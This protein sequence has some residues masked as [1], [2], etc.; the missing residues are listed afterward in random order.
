[1]ALLKQLALKYLPKPLLRRIRASHY[2][3]QLRHYPLASEP[4]LLGCRELLQPGDVVIDVGANIGVYTRFCSEY[5]GA[6]GHVHSLEPIPE[7]F[8][9]LRTNVDA[10]KLGNVTLYPYAA[11]D[12]DET[13][14]A[15]SM[16]DYASGGANIYEARLSSQGDIPVQTKRLDSLFPGCQPRLIKVDAEGH[17]FA[18]V[19]GARALMTACRPLWVI[20]VTDSRVFDTMRA[21]DYEPWVW[22]AGAFRPMA[23]DDKRPNYFFFHRD[24][25]PVP[26][27]A[28]TV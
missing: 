4:D 28:K 22:Q 5:V 24:D 15:M 20:E 13:H 16:P 14:A 11:S 2:L 7:T 6:S 1:M 18:C 3:H 17:E 12:V 8:S 21:A 10:L 9:Y 27:L 19:E 23:E 25:R 26:H